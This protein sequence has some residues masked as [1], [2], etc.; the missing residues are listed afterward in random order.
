MLVACNSGEDA[1]FH[2]PMTFSIL[3]DHLVFEFKVS[4]GSPQ[5]AENGLG[6]RFNWLSAKVGVL[7]ERWGLLV[8]EISKVPG[9][10]KTFLS[11]LEENNGEVLEAS[12][13]A[14]YAARGLSQS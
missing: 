1:F 14:G 11:R 4:G 10:S 2:P 12:I 9:L 13:E 5:S 3:P 7:F 6:V 8:R